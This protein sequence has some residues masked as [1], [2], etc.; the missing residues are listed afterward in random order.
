MASQTWKIRSGEVVVSVPPASV[1]ALAPT[2]GVIRIPPLAIVRP[3]VVSSATEAAVL[4]RSELIVTGEAPMVMTDGLSTLVVAP[5]VKTAVLTVFATTLPPL[6]VAQLAPE[7]VVAQ[8]PRRPPPSRP[9]T[10]LA[11]TK[12]VPLLT[13]PKSTAPPVWRVIAPSAR[14]VPKRAVG[15]PL[16]VMEPPGAMV[17]LAKVWVCEAVC[18]VF[19]VCVSVPPPRTRTL[20][21]LMSV[22][23]AVVRVL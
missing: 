17:V 7:L 3:A 6:S 21:G 14:V 19:G 20:S 8:P 13:M 23:G 16:L 4:K 11:V 10:E 1:T 12:P 2:V 15:A 22:V 18:V 9:A 5:P